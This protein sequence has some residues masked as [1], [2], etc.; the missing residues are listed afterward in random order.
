MSVNKSNQ[1]TLDNGVRG[2]KLRVIRPSGAI[3]KMDQ[4]VTLLLIVRDAP[5]RY[6]KMSGAIVDRGEGIPDYS[7]Y[8]VWDVDRFEKFS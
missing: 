3:L 8:V 2:E 5:G 1:L 6:K 4:I 7:S